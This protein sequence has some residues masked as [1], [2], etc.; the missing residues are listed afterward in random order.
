MDSKTLATVM[1]I[2][3]GILLIPVCIGIIGGV[4][5]VIGSVLGAVFGIIGGM[6]SA[7]FGVIG[8][9]FGWIF[10]GDNDREWT[11]HFFHWDFFTVFAVALVIILITRRK[12]SGTQ[13]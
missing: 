11:N 1:L 13:R 3:I 12:P 7:I 6:L 2:F 10:Y 8:G 4:F 5:G 9:I